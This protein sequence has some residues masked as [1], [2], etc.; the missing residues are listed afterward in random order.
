MSSRVTTVTS[1]TSLLR[2]TTTVGVVAC[3]TAGSNPTVL[4]TC[5]CSIRCCYCWTFLYR[6][7][8]AKKGDGLWGIWIVFVV[9]T[10]VLLVSHVVLPFCGI[11]KTIQSNVA[12]VLGSIN[13]ELLSRWRSD[14]LNFIRFFLA[15]SNNLAFLLPILGRQVM[16]EIGSWKAV[17]ETSPADVA[18]GV[19]PIRTTLTAASLSIK[20]MPE[21]LWHQHLKSPIR[22]WGVSSSRYC[23]PSHDST[24]STSSTGTASSRPKHNH[25]SATH[26][27]T[28][29]VPPGG[30]Q[31]IF[32]LRTEAL[33]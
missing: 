20:K 10:H 19:S 3:S 14:R 27:E 12:S 25:P 4:R 23:R 30:R 6:S 32:V 29:E 5:C 2:A 22:T 24:P 17:T 26:Y 21:Q 28:R 15:N 31:C 18:S 1:S 33:C 9:S 11:I 13:R 16:S 8:S 7:A